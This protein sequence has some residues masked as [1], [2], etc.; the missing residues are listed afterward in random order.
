MNRIFKITGLLEGI[1]SILLFFVAMPM[2]YLFNNK[3]LISP[4]GMAHGVL[5]VVFIALAIVLYFKEKW[6][7]KKF[8]IIC[9][10]AFIPLGTFY[11]DKKYLKNV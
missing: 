2:K 7:F 9:I 3:S 1:S 6:N 8:V 10:C 4:V 5:F 11:V